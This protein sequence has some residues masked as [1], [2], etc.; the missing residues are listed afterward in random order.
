MGE[1]VGR[2]RRRGPPVGASAGTV[3]TFCIAR[4]ALLSAA[5]MLMGI[6]FFVDGYE[7]DNG[8]AD[9]WGNLCKDFITCFGCAAVCV[10]VCACVYV[11]V[12]VCACVCV[13]VRVCACVCVCVGPRVIPRPDIPRALPAPP[14]PPPTPPPLR[15]RAHVHKRRG[16]RLLRICVSRAA[17][18][19]WY[20]ACCGVAPRYHVRM[21]M[22]N[23]PTFANP[24]PGVGAVLY[25]H[26]GPARPF[27]SR[28]SPIPS[29][30]AR[31]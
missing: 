6:A 18:D 26:V 5:F 22:S 19:C 7:F 31:C 20:F 9:N 25:R 24:S 28:R 21:G 13:C 23:P 17:T 27:C 1:G 4:G 30:C 12:R 16:G 14:C 10:R 11:C 29:F 2:A 3:R 15:T 8:D